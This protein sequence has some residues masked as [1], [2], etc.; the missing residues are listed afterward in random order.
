VTIVYPSPLKK[1][2]AAS[3]RW[4]TIFLR[5]FRFYFSI[6]LLTHYVLNSMIR[7]W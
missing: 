3:P 2:S 6:F 5:K 7:C 4:K 1:T